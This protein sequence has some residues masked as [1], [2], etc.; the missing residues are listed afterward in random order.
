MPLLNP[1]CGKIIDRKKRKNTETR[2][3]K[4]M[5][6]QVQKPSWRLL[7]LA[8]VILALASC[9]SISRTYDVKVSTETEQKAIFISDIQ[10]GEYHLPGGGLG[11]A[12]GENTGRG[13]SSV[14]LGDVKIPKTATYRWKKRAH[15]SKYKDLPLH[16]YTV[17]L[18]TDFPDVKLGEVLMFLFLIKMDNTVTVKVIAY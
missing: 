16:E 7:L 13:R 18:P 3:L 10:F 9:A 4:H 12:V 1:G 8:P 6:P 2:I 17:Q 11:G 15:Y 5:K 14:G